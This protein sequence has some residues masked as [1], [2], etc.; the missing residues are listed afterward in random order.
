MKPSEW[1]AGMSVKNEDGDARLLIGRD[2]DW[3]KMDGK[4]G[5]SDRNAGGWRPLT[6][7]DKGEQ[8]EAGGLYADGR[9]DVFRIQK[10][11]STDCGWYTDIVSDA[12][13]DG[14][15]APGDREMG[16]FYPLDRAI[17][18][19]AQKQSPVCDDFGPASSLDGQTVSTHTWTPAEKDSCHVCC[20]SAGPDSGPIGPERCPA[21]QDEHYSTEPTPTLCDDGRRSDGLCV[22]RN[23]TGGGDCPNCLAWREESEAWRL[24]AVWLTVHAPVSAEVRAREDAVG[25]SQR[26]AQMAFLRPHFKRGGR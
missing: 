18:E 3:W 11:W 17:Y 16:K 8:P 12:D 14:R 2:G 21:C 23:M 6:F 24:H 15:E 9:G 20:E 22:C 26:A 25:K 13:A 10:R 1:I 4:F 5:L 19:A 7:K